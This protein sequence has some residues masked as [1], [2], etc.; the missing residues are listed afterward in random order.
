[1]KIRRCVSG[2]ALAITARLHPH[3]SPTST[4]LEAATH[5]HTRRIAGRTCLS[6][7][8]S[9]AALDSA[10]PTQGRFSTMGAVGVKA[11]SV[12]SVAPRSIRRYPDRLKRNFPIAL[13]KVGSHLRAN[14]NNRDPLSNHH[15]ALLQQCM[16]SSRDNSIGVSNR[17]FDSGLRVADARRRRRRVWTPGWHLASPPRG[18]QRKP[19]P[20]KT[21]RSWLS[22]LHISLR[23]V[24]FAWGQ[25]YGRGNP[26]FCNTYAPGYRTLDLARLNVLTGEEGDYVY[27]HCPAEH[28]T[29]GRWTHEPAY[30]T[31]YWHTTL[32]TD[33]FLRAPGMDDCTENYIG[34]QGRQPPCPP[35][36]RRAR[37]IELLFV[38]RDGFIIKQRTDLP[39]NEAFIEIA[40][41]AW[42]VR[43]REHKRVLQCCVHVC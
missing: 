34:G 9:G 1:M 13:H 41:Q 7:P 19:L 12:A 39:G 17:L 25:I 23:H 16:A 8:A 43:R 36:N 26:A 18:I 4:V 6:C 11:S 38:R 24:T 5:T 29:S 37:F 32:V 42:Q 3:T 10:L 27:A 2:L 15:G 14:E 28:D 22:L 31:L 20:H 35:Q 21:Q 40:T 33:H 30:Q